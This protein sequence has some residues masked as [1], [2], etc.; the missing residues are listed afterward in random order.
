MS[1][2]SVFISYNPQSDVEM[3]LAVRLHTI[4]GVNGLQINLPDR[5][6]FQRPDLTEETKHR[7][8]NSQYFLVFST[9]S[10]STTVSQEIQYA[11]TTYNDPSKIIVIYDSRIGGNLQL[12]KKCTEIFINPADDLSTAVNAIT[13]SIKSLHSKSNDTSVGLGGLILAG[14]GLFALAS[15]FDNDPPPRKRTPRKAAKKGTAAKKRKR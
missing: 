1:L 7:I 5:L 9:G 15:L 4:G 3:T 11:F 6:S 14:L 2:P 8:R 10:L 13:T 12:A